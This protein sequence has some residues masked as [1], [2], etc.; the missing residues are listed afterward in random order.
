MTKPD[1]MIRLFFIIPLLLILF[2]CDHSNKKE[3]TDKKQR[4]NEYFLSG[5]AKK[6]IQDYIGAIEDYSRAI[7]IYPDDWGAYTNR[8]L[9]KEILQDYRGALAD[10]TKVIELGPKDAEIYVNRG[11]V[12]NKLQDYIGAIADLTKA[13]ELNPGLGIAYYNRGVVKYSQQQKDSGCLDFSKAGELG[14]KDAY[15]LI[16]EFCQ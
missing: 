8:A 5:N 11:N 7:N 16:K 15:S 14:Y 10:Y 13:I 1:K 12:K 6:D 3:E 9:V 2:S 4:S